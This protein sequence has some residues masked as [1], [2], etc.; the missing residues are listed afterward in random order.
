MKNYRDKSTFSHSLTLNQFCH[1]ELVSGSHA[2]FGKMLKQVQHDMRSNKKAA[3]SLVELLMALL[4]ASLLMAALAPVMT[5][6]FGEVVSFEGTLPAVKTKTHQIEYGSKECSVIKT[7]TDG[8]EYCEGEFIVPSGYNGKMKVTLIGGGGGGSTAPTAGYVEYT[9]AGSTNEFR[10]PAGVSKLETTLVSGGAG[11]GAGGYLP[12]NADFTK[13]NDEKWIVP[14]AAKGEN[15]LITACGGGGGG[16]GGLDNNWCPGG[17]EPAG[18]GGSGGYIKDRLFTVPSS[19]A[20]IPL[21]IGGQGGRG[22]HGHQESFSGGFTECGIGSG[23]GGGDYITALSQIT[24]CSN[25]GGNG[26]SSHDGPIRMG[27][28]GGMVNDTTRAGGGIYYTSELGGS[29]LQLIAGGIGNNGG[30]GGASQYNPQSWAQASTGAGGGYYG[31]GGGG[32]TQSGGGGGGGGPTFFNNILFAS[33]GGGGGSIA[34]CTGN[35]IGIVGAGGGGGG[36]TGGGNGGNGGTP[37]PYQGAG[38]PGQAGA[39]GADGVGYK[40]G[41][42]KDSPFP[43]TNCHGGNGAIKNGAIGTAGGTGAIRITYLDYGAGGSGGGAGSIVPIRPLNITP[44]EL[45]KIYI[46]KGGTGGKK[47]YIQANGTTGNII[48]ATRGLPM[49]DT[50]LGNLTTFVKNSA[51]SVLIRTYDD[52]WAPTS[53]SPTGQIY[54]WNESPWY[55]HPGSI[56]DGTTRANNAITAGFESEIGRSAGNGTTRGDIDFSNTHTGGNGG[57]TKLFNSTDHCSPGSGGTAAS[58]NGKNGAGYGG[59]AGGGGYSLAN[60]GSGSGGYARISW[61]KYWNSTKNKY[62]YAEIGAGGAGASGNVLKFDKFDVKSG[63]VIKIRIGKGGNGGSVS[64]NSVIEAQNGGNTVFAHGTTKQ[65]SAGGGKKG[66]FPTIINN[67][68]SNGIGGAISTLCKYGNTDYFNNASYCTKGEIGETSLN[69]KGG[70]GGSITS[71]GTGGFGGITGDNSNGG[72]AEGYGAGG[73]G[74]GIREIG[75]PSISTYNPN[76]GGKGTNGRIMLEWWE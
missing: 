32:A 73:G 26:G 41:K 15:V 53:G 28:T 50:A 8:S 16:G 76:I 60:G 55:G 30:N 4:V 12:I 75:T 74:A 25:L 71:Y 13:P 11:G 23:A 6:K 38:S 56:S 52:G 3:F 63:E 42:I 46:G 62:E 17:C 47:A 66:G 44:N 43:E 59:C 40:G 21:R 61:N 68:V 72:N 18:G 57:R 34:A 9:L 39:G 2:K 24:S 14:V 37:S 33:G 22:S 67:V 1:P 35:C 64:N 49:T 58:P 7:D 20:N 45:I 69:N 29:T 19:L 10:V 27:A 48:E 5:R 65:L 54:S 31:G 70:K 51:N 36:G